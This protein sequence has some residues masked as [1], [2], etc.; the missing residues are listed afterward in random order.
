M[1][2]DLRSLLLAA[3]GVAALAGA[4]VSWGGRPQGKGFPAVLL[5]LVSERRGHGLAGPEALADARVQVDCWALVYREA[6]ALGRAVSAAL[7]GYAG[8]V[9]ATRF[10]GVFQENGR[11][12]SEVRAADGGDVVE[13]LFRTSLDFRVR[14]QQE[15]P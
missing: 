14:H 8:I 12:T 6:K 5:H 10:Q 1:E 15:E 13:Q 7:D 3:P 9:G 4:R 11:D 2:E